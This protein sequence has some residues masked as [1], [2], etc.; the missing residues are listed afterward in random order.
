MSRGERKIQD[1][2]KHA[3][4]V[5]APLAVPTNAIHKTRGIISASTQTLGVRFRF[6]FL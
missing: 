3:N 1:R 2:T 4:R 6:S 5:E